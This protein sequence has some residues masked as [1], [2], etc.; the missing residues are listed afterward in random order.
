VLPPAGYT[1]ACAWP[2][3]SSTATRVS[4]PIPMKPRIDLS[5]APLT[6]CLLGS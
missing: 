6:P 1:A 3:T 4:K 2:A 5:S